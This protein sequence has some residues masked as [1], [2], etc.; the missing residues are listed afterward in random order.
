MSFGRKFN[1]KEAQEFLWESDVLFFYK[2]EEVDYH[3]DENRKDDPYYISPE[4]L[5]KDKRTLNLNDI[6]GWAWADA[7]ELEDKDFPEV[8]R[9]LWQYGM[10]GVIYWAS[11]KRKNMRS[12][13]HHYNRF[14]QFVETEEKIANKFDSHSK[15]A[16]SKQSYKIK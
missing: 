11:K 1:L 2:G 14:I 6:F 10:C 4:D 13:F 5:E 9:L 7:E 8:A 12:E 15:Y 16:Y 3:S